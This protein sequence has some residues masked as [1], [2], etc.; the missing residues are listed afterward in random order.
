MVRSGRPCVVGGCRH[1]RLCCVYRDSHDG[2][3]FSP[4]CTHSQIRSDLRRPRELGTRSLHALRPLEDG[5]TALLD[6]LEGAGLAGAFDEVEFL[7][8]PMQSWSAP[9]AEF[10]GW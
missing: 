9:L 2:S 6:A 8:P 4:T 3:H 7:L 10:A 5:D 1:L